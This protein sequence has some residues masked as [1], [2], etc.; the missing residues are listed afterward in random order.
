MTKLFSRLRGNDKAVLEITTRLVSEACDLELDNW[1]RRMEFTRQLKR[2]GRY[3]EASW[4]YQFASILDPG[5]TDT[6][7]GMIPSLSSSQWRIRRRKQQIEFL[8]L[9]QD[10]ESFNEEMLF[11]QLLINYGAKTQM[12]LD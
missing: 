4:Q 1:E 7:E 8:E 6:L 5:N 2:L 11:V 3:D 9:V 12:Q 10:E